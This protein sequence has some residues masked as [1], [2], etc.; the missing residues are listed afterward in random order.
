MTDQTQ[1]PL[2]VA[3]MGA[4][5]IARHMAET[6]NKMAASEEYASVAK[7][8]AIASRSQDKADAFAKDFN[9]PHAYGT[10]EAMLAD[11]DIDLVYIAT[12]HNVHEENGI[13]CMRAGKNILV[14]KS[15]TANE[16]QALNLLDVADDTGM[17]CTEAIWTRYMPSR[18]MIDEII[19]SGMIGEVT[20]ISA[21]LSYPVSYK[22]R[23]TDPSLAGGALLDVGVYPLNFIDMIMGA[24]EIKDM[25]TIMVPYSTGVDASN[26]TTLV[27]DDNTMAVATS[28]MLCASDR[29]GIVR[30]TNGYLICHNINNVESI[31]VF[32]ADHKLTNHLHVPEQ[33]TG[34]EYE[35]A[36]AVKAIREGK[37]ECI[38]MTHADT[39]RIM[40]LMDQIRQG[41]NL[42]YP[43]E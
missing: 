12:P 14:E 36:A 35:V 39:L 18:A 41:W 34:Y 3:I 26:S 15:F 43:F 1:R 33:L 21:D 23:M 38:E 13:A 9:L 24:Q 4:G 10:Y 11:P 2:N 20:S 27:Y 16:K 42:T 7:P 31:D 25:S 8:Y 22:S 6:L 40:H 37:H 5:R 29:D 17:L 32:D 30:G 28:S 19:S